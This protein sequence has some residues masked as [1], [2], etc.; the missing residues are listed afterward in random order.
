[1][2][3]KN[4]EFRKTYV[5]TGEL[6]IAGGGQVTT[7]LHWSVGIP[8]QTGRPARHGHGHYASRNYGARPYAARWPAVS[9]LTV[10]PCRCAGTSTTLKGI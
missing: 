10:P 4:F 1:V 7:V 8:G 5:T 9:C 6:L 3:T 2:E